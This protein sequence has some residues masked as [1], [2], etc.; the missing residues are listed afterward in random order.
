MLNPSARSGKQALD[1]V[2]LEVDGW[3]P[4]VSV[5]RARGCLGPDDYPTDPALQQWAHEEGLLYLDA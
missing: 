1:A 4:G 5:D 2:G 3:W